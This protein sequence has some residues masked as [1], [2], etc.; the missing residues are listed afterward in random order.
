MGDRLAHPNKAKQTWPHYP[1]PFLLSAAF[2]YPLPFPRSLT[3]GI[4]QLAVPY[5]LLTTAH[6]YLEC[7][8]LSQAQSHQAAHRGIVF[9]VLFT[10][11]STHVHVLWCRIGGRLPALAH[12]SQS[13][14]EGGCPRTGACAAVFNEP[15]HSTFPVTFP[16]FTVAMYNGLDAEHVSLGLSVCRP[17]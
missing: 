10:L 2:P 4:W 7:W 12:W 11:G 5:S 3:A 14:I 1:F 8:L 17:F 13:R 9:A 16:E 15:S 6:R